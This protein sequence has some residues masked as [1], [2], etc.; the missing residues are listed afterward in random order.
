MNKKMHISDGVGERLREER[1]RLGLNQTEFGA[2]GSV[3]RGTQK[4][5][6]LGTN[7]PD[8]RYLASLEEAGVDTAYVLSGRRELL[9]EGGLTA[10]ESRILENYRSLSES[11]QASVERLTTALA[12]M[13]KK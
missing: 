9:S 5:Y 7:S 6:E 3:S 1:E 4:A 12:V 11:D 10:I 2:L 8:L 13:P